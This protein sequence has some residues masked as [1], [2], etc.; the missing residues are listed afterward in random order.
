MRNPV[1]VLVVDDE[2]RMRSFLCQEL[3]RL[4][5]AAEPA[6]SGEEA[7][8][9]ANERDYDVILMDLRMEG[10]TGLEALAKIRSVDPAPE[11]IIL[12]GHGTID[13]AIE[14]M[15]V[16]AYHYLTKPFKLRDL[17]IHIRKAHEKISLVR[18][19]RQL[20]RLVRAR[21]SDAGIVGGSAAMRRVLDLVA[22]VA[23]TESSVLVTG[24]SGTGK[25]LVATAIHNLSPRASFPFVVVN[26]GALQEALLES[27]LFGHE[28]GAFTGAHRPKE[29]LF[30]VAHQ[31][32]LFLDEIG[33][34]S[35][36]LQAKLLRAL[37]TGEIRRLGGEELHRGRPD[38]GRDERGPERRGSGP[39]G[40]GRTSTTG[41]RRSR[42]RSRPC[43]SAPRTCATS[44]STSSPRSPSPGR[45]RSRSPRKRSRSSPAT[46][47]RATCGSSGT[48]WS[49]C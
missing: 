28:K 44:C 18:R 8:A 35:P 7:L 27:E 15:R 29:G 34:M 38:G 36:T 45:G 33:E 22:K 25:E 3:A 46:A 26:C 23:P 32:T 43:G 16:G 11:V 13:T 30:E 6:A 31:G 19:S 49:G 37:E 40:S 2:E 5:F 42:S 39:A 4:G 21:I 20:E 48:P 9:R 41:S 14:A 47:G 1:R 17:E 24:E 12:T 10:M